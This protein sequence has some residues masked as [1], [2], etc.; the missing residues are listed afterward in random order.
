MPAQIEKK[1]T[2]EKALSRLNGEPFIYYKVKNIPQVTGYKESQ[3][4]NA[5][6]EFLS[7][8]N[9]NVCLVRKKFAVK[10][11]IKINDGL[12][13]RVFETDHLLDVKYPAPKKLFSVLVSE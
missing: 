5:P 1:S 3:G 9:V 10:A 11:Y 13:S 2:V 12:A 8:P 6:K 4:N 7:N